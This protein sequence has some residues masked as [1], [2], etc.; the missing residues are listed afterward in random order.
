M[1]DLKYLRHHIDEVVSRLQTRGYTFDT[2]QF[3]VLEKQHRTL[4][5]KVQ[6][7]QEKTNRLAKQIGEKQATTVGAADKELLFQKSRATK[8][9]L[10]DTSK[11]LQAIT[12]QLTTQLL[13]VPNLPDPSVPIGRSAKDNQLVKTWGSIPTYTFEPK[14]HVTLTDKVN[15]R[16]DFK[17]AALI[18]GSRFVIL[19]GSL[20]R[21]ERALIQWMLDVHTQEHGY[22]EMAVPYIV[23]RDS[24]EATGQLP[25]FEA[26]LFKLEVKR[27]WYLIPTGEVPLTNL[28]RQHI[29]EETDLPTKYVA[30]TPCFRSEAGSYGKDVKGMIRQHQ[31]DKVE[32]VQFVAPHQAE[33]SLL[34]LREE[35]ERIL[36]K[37]HLPYRVMTLCTGDLG[38]AATKTYDLEVWLPG[39]NAF[40]EISSCSYMGDFQGRRLKAR[41]RSHDN[42]K[43]LKPVHTLN[44]SGLAVGRTLVA[45][46]ENYQSK[47][48]SIQIPEVLQPYIGGLSVIPPITKD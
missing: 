20:A 43:Q 13:Q 12:L 15:S 22:V 47:D 42:K 18:T 10:H 2:Q 1:L 27:D 24:L 14:D 9:Q 26:D 44:G 7:L 31:F 6:D 23:N 34:Q 33:K 45:I 37:L 40:R 3:I 29:F 11:T 4:Q 17:Q 30:Y 46:L 8:L 19:K 39:Q 38:F 21:L 35:A 41:W 28:G 32:L 36:Q 25:M 5:E 16:M 48:G